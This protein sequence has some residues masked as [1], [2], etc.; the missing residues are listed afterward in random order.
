MGFQQADVRRRFDFVGS[1]ERKGQ[2]LSAR[3]AG[4]RVGKG[5]S[6]AWGYQVISSSWRLQVTFVTIVSSRKEAQAHGGPQVPFTL[7]GSGAVLLSKVR[8]R[9]LPKWT[10]KSR[11]GQKSQSCLKITPHHYSDS[12]GGRNR[13]RPC[14]FQTP[15]SFMHLLPIWPPKLRNAKM[16]TGPHWLCLLF[17][18]NIG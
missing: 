15:P 1:L 14:L 11:F 3:I 13:Q 9:I 8:L 4:Q 17:I 7:P 6:R 5:G 16:S 10:D 12:S 2:S 18:T